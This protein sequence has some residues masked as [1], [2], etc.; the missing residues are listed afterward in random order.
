ME[1][2]KTHDCFAKLSA[3][4]AL[5][6]KDRQ[7]ARLF[8][9][10]DDAVEITPE[11][12]HLQK[13]TEYRNIPILLAVIPKFAKYELGKF[14]ENHL[15][16]TPAV[17]GYSHENHADKSEKKT[18]LGSNRPVN[19]VLSSLDEARLKMIRIF[20]HHLS[21][22]LVPPWNRIDVAIVDGARGLGFRAIS[23][24]GWKNPYS[25]IS[26]INTHVDIIN[27]RKNASAKSIAEVTDDLTENLQIARKNAFAPIGILTHHLVHSQL[28]WHMLEEVLEYLCGH[29]N[30]KWVNADDLIIN[31][32]P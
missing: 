13:M 31:I 3:E 32:D 29:E 2:S 6:A 23:G 12:I 10:D 21:D 1:K 4:L 14:V 24:F 17:H 5:W 15:L 11:L 19:Q 27:W 25:G 9:R 7:I 18:E 22:I 26:W 28:C 30:V 20:G 16:I 8:L